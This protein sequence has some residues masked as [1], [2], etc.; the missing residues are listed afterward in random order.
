MNTCEM[1]RKLI[2]QAR[3]KK[4]DNAANL[5]EQAA[6]Q[7][8]CDGGATAQGGGTGAGGGPPPLPTDP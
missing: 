5:L 2:D 4:L 7:L 3:A 8:G 1:L 6:A